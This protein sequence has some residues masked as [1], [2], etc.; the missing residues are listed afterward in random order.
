LSANDIA[1]F[2]YEYF[3]GKS[4]GES[5]QRLSSIRIWSYFIKSKEETTEEEEV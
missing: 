5:G 3:N 4:K 1:E 2:N